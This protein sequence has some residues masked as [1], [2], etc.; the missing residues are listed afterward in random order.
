MAQAS[1]SPPPSATT[2]T[3]TKWQL[4]ARLASK[5]HIAGDCC[6]CTPRMPG[7]PRARTPNGLAVQMAR[8]DWPTDPSG[9]RV[10]GPPRPLQT[11]S[12]GPRLR[13]SAVR[14]APGPPP[15]GAT[16][17]AEP[18]PPPPWGRGGP[19]APRETW[20]LVLVRRRRGHQ[21]SR[22]DLGERLQKVCALGGT[23]GRE[24]PRN[25]LFSKNVYLKKTKNQQNNNKKPVPPPPPLL[26]LFRELSALPS[27]MRSKCPLPR[28]PRAPPRH[29]PGGRRVGSG[30]TARGR[31]VR[32][33]AQPRAPAPPPAH[34]LGE[35]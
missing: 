15:L 26:S 11:R 3:V 13:A 14:C 10:P 4:G 17:P 32:N 20:L 9:S 23:L 27:P 33:R 7:H 22:S 31:S 16:V 19:R 25:D 34:T 5:R 12:P 2:A 24:V 21:S 6:P 35:V 29:K 30:L 8:A 28:H 1:R 18:G